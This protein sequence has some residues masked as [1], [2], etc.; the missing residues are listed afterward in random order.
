MKK[1]IKQKLLNLV[2]FNP[3]D[4]CIKSQVTPRHIDISKYVKKDDF[5]SFVNGENNSLEISSA[6]GIVVFE[7][8]LKKSSTAQEFI[9]IVLENNFQITENRERELTNSFEN[10]KKKSI[11]F[12]VDQMKAF[13]KQFLTLNRN[14]KTF[15]AD[16]TIWPLYLS[17]QFLKGKLNDNLGIKAPLIIFKTEIVEEGGKIYLRK[18]QDEPI[19][20]E[21]I[22]VIM[23]KEHNSLISGDDLLNTLSFEDNVERFNKMVGYNIKFENNVLNSFIQED[24]KKIIEKYS[25]LE[26]DPSALLGIFEPGGSSLKN[27]LQKIIDLDVDPFESQMES[28]FKSNKYFEDKIIKEPSLIEIDKP[29]NIYQKYAVASSLHQSTLIYGPPGTGKSEVIANII[30]NALIK[31]KTTLMVSEKKAALDVLTSR[32][33][34]LSQFAL[35]ICDNK[36]KEDFYKKIDNLNVLLGTQWYRETSKFS[37]SANIEPI[38][39]DSDELMFFKNYQDWYAELLLLVKKHWNI[40]DYTD[41]IYKL[42]Y[43]EYQLLKNELGDQI[44]NEWLQNINIEGIGN[45][46]LFD[47]VKKI[48]SNYNFAKIDDLFNEYLKFKKFIKKYGLLENRNNEELAKYLKL[49]ANKIISNN[50]LTEKYLLGGEKLTSKINLYFEFLEKYKGKELSSFLDR[51]YKE[52]K[53]F[54]GLL[55][56]FL[57]FKHRTL[58]R[59]SNLKSLTKEQ[60][61]ENISIA[62]AF[63][64]KYKNELTKENW[65]DF[66]SNNSN[67]I[68]RFLDTFNSAN[69]DELKEVIFC[70]F[71]FN[72]SIIDDIEHST[73]QLKDIKK[74]G[75]IMNNIIPIFIDFTKNKEVL[76][77]QIISELIK[78]KEFL[79]FDVEFLTS[80]SSIEEVFSPM[81]QDIIQEWE[82]ISL[83][84]IRYLYLNPLIVFDLNKVQPILQ[85]VTTTINNEQFT[86]LKV[87]SMWNDIIKEIPMF[88]DIKGIH[89]QD[90]VTQLRRESFRAAELVEEIAFKKYI[91]N[92]RNYLIK[93]SKDDKDEIANLL[94]I[95]SSATNPPI[96]QFVKKYY[97]AL[98]KLFPI[99]VARPDNV[100]DMVPLNAEEFDYGIFDEASQI[101]IERSYPLV[102]RCNIKV[103]S[104][105]DKQLKPSTFFMSKSNNVEFDI[106]DF[107]RV[108][109]LLERAKVSWWNEYHLK[110]HY[111]SDSKELIEFSNKFIYNNNLEVASKADITD[112]GIEVYDVN[113]LWD[114][115]NK[116]EADKILEILEEQYASYEKILII[117]FNSKQSQLIENLI[118][119]KQSKFPEDLRKLIEKGAV[120]VTNLENVQGNEGDLVI[121]SVSYGKNVDGIIKSNFGPL[122]ANG[123]SNRLNVAITR[124]RKKMIIVKSLYGDQIKVGNI[125]N[126]NA[127]IFKK[128]ITYIDAIKENK[129]IEQVEINNEEAEVISR[130]ENAVENKNETTNNIV[131]TP[132]KVELVFSSLIVK[133][134]YGDLIKNLSEKYKV[135]NDYAVGSKKIDLVILNRQTKSVL[136]AVIIEPWKTNRSVKEMI[137]DIDRQYFLEDRGYNTFRIKE[138]EWNI[139][140]NKLISKLKDSLTNNSNK[141][142]DYVIWQTSK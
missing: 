133:E 5:F 14:A 119:E 13:K 117:T 140:K 132:K 50:K 72:G 121:L 15:E 6:S 131:S 3:I 137:E 99:W 57:I 46:T 136:K 60:L 65:L 67:N 95:A 25:S 104:G 109:S 10:N 87:I 103:V 30:C 78:Y 18:L 43:S 31:G 63:T 64:N 58:D 59:D 122:I 96:T 80:L 8:Q 40:E 138:Y 118:F 42:D 97:S 92:L 114:Q 16:T 123:G 79:K 127:L 141:K 128:F 86:R 105:D 41:G 142:I 29:L 56:S 124:A 111:R 49:V 91:N 100:A 62:E 76:E 94:R 102:Y 107:D 81:I 38:R 69:N 55:S 112:R 23:N 83:P 7:E 32:I 108:E 51:T 126:K 1:A 135:I 134:I 98:K 116:D 75:K 21:K 27:D 22:Q 129:S 71:I 89:L 125:N 12:Y 101:S 77:S 17:F 139:D 130:D 52:K 82:W 74:N 115:V 110:N 19:I 54:L 26:I 24:A 44:C 2:T 36:H 28:N 9:S 33:G 88:L 48:Y 4:Y 39:F 93:L 68:N 66:L 11:S 47:A 120:I 34:S 113:G 90:I 53:N 37:R 106:D 45:T 85:L 73:L 70:E 61:L 84:Y 35:Y 20:N